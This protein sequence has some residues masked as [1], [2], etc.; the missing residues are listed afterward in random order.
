MGDIM[1]GRYWCYSCSQMVNPTI[2]PTIKCP[3][4]DSGFVEEISSMR[5]FSNTNGIDSA[6]ANNFSFL[7]PIPILLGIIS[8]LGTSRS[9]IAGRDQTDVNNSSQDALDD[10][11]G[12]DFEALLMRRRRRGSSALHMLED[13]PNAA[14]SEPENPEINRERRERMIVSDPFNDGALIV[15]ASFG[16][17]L[18]G[19]GWDLL[20]QYLSENDMNH[21]GVPPAL[22][23]AI[24]AIP[25]V[26]VDDIL[27][28]SVCL[29]DIEIGSETKEMPCKHKFHSGCITPWLELHS[30]CPVCRYKLRWDYSEI[31]ANVTRNGEGR[32][33]VADARNGG[34]IGTGRQY[35]IPIPWHYERLLAL[36]GSGSD[37]TSASSLEALPGSEN[38]PQTND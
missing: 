37:S 14:V 25:N 15:H 38:T 30:S 13:T 2:E 8:G 29:E 5:Y 23:E 19:H 24:E 9:R 20:L 34:E 4:C 26:T 12:R 35:W 6:S 16:D 17:Y 27:H 11:L 32:V 31:E 1:V 28:C 22:K 10:E 3:S 18:M 7:A 21:H 36:P 33:G